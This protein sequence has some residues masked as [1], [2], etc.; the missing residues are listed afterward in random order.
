M[1]HHDDHDEQVDE[2]GPEEEAPGRDQQDA[3]LTGGGGEGA[4]DADA[5]DAAGT[6]AADAV[7]DD[8]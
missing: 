4:A 7:G 8:D 1:T 3:G 5:E 6:S 2:P